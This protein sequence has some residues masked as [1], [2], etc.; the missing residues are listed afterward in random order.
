MK[1]IKL[2][3]TKLH[4]INC[5]FDKETGMATFSN[6]DQ[7]LIIIGN[8][9][10]L[11]DVDWTGSKFIVLDTINHEETLMPLVLGF[12]RVGNNQEE[13]D[14]KIHFGLL[15][16]IKVRITFDMKHFN[17]QT[18]FLGRTPGKTKTV[19][20]GKKIAIDEIGKMGISIL[21]TEANQ[22][23]QICD[24]FLTDVEPDY[25]LEDAKLVDELGQLCTKDWPYKTRTEDELIKYLKQEYETSDNA[26]YTD[27]WDEYGGSKSKELGATGFFRTH[28][29]GTRW[30]IVDPDGFAF[31][32][33]GLDVISAGE[34]GKINGIEKLFK[35]IP[36]K[37]GE[38]KDAFKYGETDRDGKYFNFAIANLIRTFGKDWWNAW[39]KITNWRLHKWGFNTVANWSDINFAKYAKMPYVIAL[40]NFPDTQIKIFRDF[41]DVFSLEYELSSELFAKQIVKDKDDK[42]L[43][44][45]FLRNEPNW[46]FIEGLNIADEMLEVDVKFESK[47]V[48]INNITERYDGDIHKLN[49]AWKTSFKAF[50]DLY[51][52]IK[53]AS[54]LSA[55]AKKDLEEFSKLM[56][57]RYVTLPSKA[58]KKYDK[59][60]L[61]LGMRY[62]FIWGEQLLSGSENFDVFSLNCYNFN[63]FEDI[64]KVGEMTNLPI[65]IGEFHFGS[66]DRGN[67]VNGL[68]AVKNQE[69]R[70]TAYSYY[71][72][73]AAASKY[74]V[75]V[76][77]FI[78]NDQAVLGRFDGECAQIGCVDV[79]HKPYDEF[80]DKITS[81]HK[82]IYHI[83]EGKIAPTKK[84][85][86]EAKRNLF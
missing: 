76:H 27:E 11:L 17:S 26:K 60:H 2:N 83:L 48:F 44:G 68:K 6:K 72:E 84:K 40:E 71:V 29:D 15:P 51:T 67:L 78:L 16:K 86:V 39:S 18:M 45:Y 7:K 28:F 22:R 25:P 33:A 4:P 64:N 73:N 3:Y 59:N 34:S 41:P 8:P 77:Y 24:L 85:A 49:E 69:E 5:K 62:A 81:T 47:K 52:P 20:M 66:L 23:L 12:W 10:H 32:S 75:G 9:N 13:P 63:A 82:N 1:I 19:V 14:F 55:T 43:I 58:V 53:F 38:F 74:C 65:M 56:I 36:E 61:N 80:V 57:S 70:G 79:C 42:Y 31:F 35:W 46:A 50:D 21:P 30:W 37:S 54:K